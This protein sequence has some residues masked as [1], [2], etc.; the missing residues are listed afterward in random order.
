M[1]EPRFLRTG[2]QAAAHSGVMRDLPAGQ[3]V[4]GLPA[5][6]LDYSGWFRFGT[7]S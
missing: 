3:T 7:V 1:A 2:T 6:P 5:V 4:R